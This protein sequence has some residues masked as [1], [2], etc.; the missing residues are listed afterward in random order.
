[1]LTC[2]HFVRDSRACGLSVDEHL[3]TCGISVCESESGDGQD[4]EICDESR[5]VNQ[6]VF[7]VFVIVW[8][9]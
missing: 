3:H 6:T 5:Y 1:M 7:P 8:Y 2:K 4:F 9:V